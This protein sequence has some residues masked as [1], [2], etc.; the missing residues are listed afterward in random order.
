[1]RKV[2]ILQLAALFGTAEDIQMVYDTY[3]KIEFTSGAL[4]EACAQADLKKIKVLMDN[5][6]CFYQG[7]FSPDFK[8]KYVEGS[9]NYVDSVVPEHHTLHV[10]HNLN[11]AV[12]Y[13]GERFKET[14]EKIL[15]VKD[16]ADM[17]D[18][19]CSVNQGYNSFPI[20]SFLMRMICQAK[21]DIADE[22]FRRGYTVSKDDIRNA[23]DPNSMYLFMISRLGESEQGI[24][25]TKL[26]DIADNLNLVI[27]PNGYRLSPLEK[28][29]SP[30]AIKVMLE[31]CDLSKY[32]KKKLVEATVA[33][34]SMGLLESLEK[35]GFLDNTNIRHTAMVFAK[36]NGYDI[37]L[38][39]LTEADIR[40]KDSVKE[41]RKLESALHGF[42]NKKSKEIFQILL[43]FNA[44]PLA[45]GTGA[46]SPSYW[47]FKSDDTAFQTEYIHYLCKHGYTDSEW[48]ALREAAIKYAG[49]DSEIT[50]Y[51]TEKLEK[52]LL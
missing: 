19:L 48:K 40:I 12:K 7:A 21:F 31:R 34:Q 11:L 8:A 14:T 16:C 52:E 10:A 18:L 51:L 47:V 30:S 9:W 15:T 6:A 42:S 43:E 25:M 36:E 22:L 20:S 46:M 1:M 24:A 45:G 23:S 26:C 41:R 29:F 13:A 44:D 28:K 2:Q 37:S 38:E 39:W 33:S 32:Q 50:K 3:Q 35:G 17:I 27:K 5:G 49:A 4:S